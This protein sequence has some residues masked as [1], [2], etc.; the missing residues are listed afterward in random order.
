MLISPAYAADAA[1]PDPIMSFLPLIV[2]FVVF[3]FLIIRPQMKRSK[4]Q[5]AMQ[6]ALQK[7]DEVITASGQLGKVI[8]LSDQ[9]VTL[10]IGGGTES[11]FQRGAIN[12]V[13]PKGTIKDL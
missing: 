12:T 5:R 13:L 6:E 2:I 9:Y 7:G 3:Y 11:I 8:K 1:Q 10:D 4:E